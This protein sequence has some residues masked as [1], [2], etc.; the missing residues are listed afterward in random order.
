MDTLDRRTILA[1]AAG[2]GCAATQSVR[3]SAAGPKTIFPVGTTTIFRSAPP[4][5][6]RRRDRCI[7]G[8]RILLHRGATMRRIR[9][10]WLGSDAG[11]AVLLQKPRRD[12]ELAIAPLRIILIPCSPRTITMR[13][14]WWR[15]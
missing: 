14:N 13:S 6:H 8:P 1:T 2:A 4:Q 12:P 5:S 11:A 10:R 9:V 7:S 3:P 15:R